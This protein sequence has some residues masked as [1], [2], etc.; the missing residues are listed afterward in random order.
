MNFVGFQQNIKIPEGH[1][2]VVVEEEIK[3]S[4]E[5]IQ[6]FSLLSEP[7][8]IS[9][10]FIHVNSL[11]SKQGGKVKFVNEAGSTSEAICTTYESGKEISLLSSEFGNYSA[12][13]VGRKDFSVKIAFQILTD[14][15]VEAKKKLEIFV[16]NLRGLISS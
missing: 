14:Q 3:S 15:P 13:V 7:Q 5:R 10:W 2:L 11:Q 16:A 8:E 9:R 1:Q 12:K 6:L 4:L